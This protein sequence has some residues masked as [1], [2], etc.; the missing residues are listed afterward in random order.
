MTELLKAA[1]SSE[2]AG[3]INEKNIQ[4]KYLYIGT[5]IWKNIIIM[6]SCRDRYKL[7]YSYIYKMF[8]GWLMRYNFSSDSGFHLLSHEYLISD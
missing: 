3:E 4:A 1:N 5:C 8:G 6:S 2:T 7:I